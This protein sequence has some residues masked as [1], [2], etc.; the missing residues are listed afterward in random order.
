MYALHNYI[1]FIESKTFSHSL[2]RSGYFM[3]NAAGLYNSV[4]SI[5]NTDRLSL[6]MNASA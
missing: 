2:R 1:T 3:L 4:M 6:G 5:G